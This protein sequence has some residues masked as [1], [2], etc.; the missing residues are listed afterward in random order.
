MGKVAELHTEAQ[1][2]GSITDKIVQR[3]NPEGFIEFQLRQT[4]TDA[5]KEL[6]KDKVMDIVREAAE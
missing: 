6:G 1:R 5:I 3:L 2:L 4:V